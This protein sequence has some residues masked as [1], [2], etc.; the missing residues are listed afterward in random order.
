MAVEVKTKPSLDDLNRHIK[1]M[2]E[3][4]RYPP[5]S[6]RGTKLYGAIAGAVVRKEIRDAAF[7]AGFYVVSHSGENVKI[8]SPPDSF[9]AKCW[10]VTN[11]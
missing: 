1:R 11:T 9:V 8:I 6:V 10:D 5:R 7:K 2:E 4:K 3:I